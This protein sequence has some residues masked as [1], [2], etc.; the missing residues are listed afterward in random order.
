M[1]KI[2][3]IPIIILIVI[4]LR[5]VIDNVIDFGQLFCFDDTPPLLVDMGRIG[6]NS[7]FEGFIGMIQAGWWTCYGS[8]F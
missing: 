3:W 8:I 5:P 1:R 4:I 7:T 2:L 6:Y